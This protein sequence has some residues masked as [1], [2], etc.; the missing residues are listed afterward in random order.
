MN[1]EE[2]YKD[3]KDL[4][5][6]TRTELKEY[7]LSINEKSY[8]AE[9][10]Y[11]WIHKKL[12]DSFDDMTNIPKKLRAGL[13]DSFSV[14]PM[15]IEKKFISAI[16]KTAK[17]LM[18]TK[19]G[20]IIESVAMQYP[21]GMSVCISSQAGC[22][23]GCSFCASTIMGLERNLTAAEMLSQVYLIQKDMGKRVDNIVVMGIGEPFD[24]YNEFIKFL[25]MISDE[26]GLNISQRSITVSTCGIVDR[27]Y[28]F[29]DEGMA[30]TLAVSLHAPY[31]ELRKTIMPVANRY[32]L[33]DIK[34]ACRYFT[35]KTGRRVTFEYAMIAGVNDTRECAERL[36]LFVKDLLCHINIIPLNEVKE[37]TCKGS[38]IKE[39]QN[40]VKYLEKRQNNVT[41]RKGM[42]RDI[43]AACGQLRRE[44][45]EMRENHTDSI[46]TDII[47]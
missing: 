26:N 41:V 32:S 20:N 5:S 44:C 46:Y 29:A 21:Y 7:M 25:N 17:Y 36:D 6:F 19:D 27:I 47:V 45:L 35:D 9:Q 40:F 1:T 15:H 23:M 31:D 12:A 2:K 30:V 39:I 28:D 33:A 22:R 3:Y 34:K 10:I 13:A 38:Y 14:R 16:D 4:M 24:N 11:E 18:C 8:R 43:E 37:R 42:G